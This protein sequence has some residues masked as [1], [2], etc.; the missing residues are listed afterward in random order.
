MSF[1]YIARNIL[2]EFFFSTCDSLLYHVI[3]IRYFLRWFQTVSTAILQVVFYIAVFYMPLSSRN[4]I[5]VVFI[6]VA[7]SENRGESCDRF[8]KSLVM[9]YSNDNFFDKERS[10]VKQLP[11]RWREI[12]VLMSYISRARHRRIPQ[13][14][15]LFFWIAASSGRRVAARDSRAGEEDWTKRKKQNKTSKAEAE[16]QKNA[17]RSRA[18]R[19]KAGLRRRKWLASW[20]REIRKTARERK[21]W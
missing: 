16:E 7:E 15:I 2:V 20:S 17:R 4:G 12:V 3:A 19:V 8:E 21:D 11:W 13:K 1:H 9:R 14:C 18:E 6:N 10:L 5:N